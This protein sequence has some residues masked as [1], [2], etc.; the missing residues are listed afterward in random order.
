MPVDHTNSRSITT[1]P[2]IRGRQTKR[3]AG[4]LPSNPPFR[5]CSCKR[6]EGSTLA[7]GGEVGARNAHLLFGKILNITAIGKFPRPGK[8][9]HSWQGMA[10]MAAPPSFWNISSA[11]FCCGRSASCGLSF[12][13]TMRS[14]SGHWGRLSQ[15]RSYLRMKACFQVSDHRC[16]DRSWPVPTPRPLTLRTRSSTSGE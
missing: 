6:P 11:P 2:P 3:A 12:A 14:T 7:R 16:L 15:T 8:S 9:Y 4:A 5:G 13:C 1:R 10:L